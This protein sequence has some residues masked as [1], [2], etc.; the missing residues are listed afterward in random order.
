MAESDS[1][2]V[3]REAVKAPTFAASRMAKNTLGTFIH[4]EMPPPLKTSSRMTSKE[5][6]I[7]PTSAFCSSSNRRVSRF[8]TF[9]TQSSTALSCIWRSSFM[10]FGS[11]FVN[12]IRRHASMYGLNTFSAPLSMSCIL[13]MALRA[14]CRYPI[15]VQRGRFPS[16]PVALNLLCGSL[17][18]NTPSFGMVLPKDLPTYK[19]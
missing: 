15:T 17:P 2:P 13:A 10:V 4:L 6:S 14:A 11:F 12:G 16:I 3:C 9:V 1:S 5:G 8:G 19:T 7:V 18:E